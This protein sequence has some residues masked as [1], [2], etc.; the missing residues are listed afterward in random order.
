M[1]VIDSGDGID[2]AK[3]AGTT[4]I[5]LRITRQRCRSS[6]LEL[7]LAPHAEGGAKLRVE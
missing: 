6:G 4:G 7:A 2:A 1:R 5:G 3:M